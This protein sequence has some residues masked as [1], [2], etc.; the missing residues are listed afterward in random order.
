M[1]PERLPCLGDRA[2]MP[3]IDVVLHEILRFLDILPLGVPHA[4]NQDTQFWGYH[5]LKV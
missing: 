1:R 5:I 4:V 2:W 3:D